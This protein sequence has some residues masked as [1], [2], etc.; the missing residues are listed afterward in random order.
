MLFL[1]LTARNEYAEIIRLESSTRRI[2]SNGGGA[3]VFR[4]RLRRR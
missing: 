1:A 3:A 4:R 2:F